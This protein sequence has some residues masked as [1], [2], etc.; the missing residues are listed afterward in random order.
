MC[1][2]NF[3]H[4]SVRQI[5]FVFQFFTQYQGTHHW[6]ISERKNK[7]PNQRKRNCLRHRFKHFTLDTL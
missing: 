6:D 3:I 7:S 4:H 2:G 1:V 5:G